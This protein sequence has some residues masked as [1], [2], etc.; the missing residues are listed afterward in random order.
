[1]ASSV[2]GRKPHRGS[3]PGARF[4]R[5]TRIRHMDTCEE[6]KATSGRVAVPG[7]DTASRN[8]MLVSEVLAARRRG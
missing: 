5:V 1:M 4:R 2:A 3:D 8:T 6:G 7:N